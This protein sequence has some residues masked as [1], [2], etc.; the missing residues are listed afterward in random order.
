MRKI[1]IVVMVFVL[2]SCN[3]DDDGGVQLTPPRLLAEVA[4]E[5]D[6]EIQE[7]LRTHTYNYEDFQN[8]IDPEFDL[9]VRIDTLAG[10]NADKDALID[11]PELMSEV[12][13]VS[14]SRFG[15]EVEET[16]IPHTLYYLVANQGGGESPTFADSTFVAYE[17]LRLD[18]TLFDSAQGAGTWFDL[19]G[20]PFAG[21]SGTIRGFQEGITHF[22]A[23]ENVTENPD[24]TFEI[25]NFGSG[26]IIMPSGLAYFSGTQVGA[27]YSSIIF[28]VNLYATNTADHDRDGVPSFQEDANDDGNLLND[29]ADGDGIADYA[30][31]DTPGDDAE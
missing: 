5:N 25:E 30:D 31:P 22:S 3:N 1:L 15:L 24:G 12:I 13:T 18:K 19:P 20:N 6:A 21:I 23:G 29:D 26:L 8:P 27:A 2:A 7:F 10:D 16:D 28:N 4:V 14:S 17:G 11:R 9:R